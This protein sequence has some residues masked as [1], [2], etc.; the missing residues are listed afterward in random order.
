MAQPER[1]KHDHEVL[2]WPTF[3]VAIRELAGEIV[4]TGFRPDLVLAIAR[5]GL[6]VGGTMAYALGTKNCA[7]I[8]VEYYTGVDERLDL[9]VMLPPVPDP[10]G[11]DDLNVLIADDVA[12]TGRTLAMV[13]E[14]CRQHVR[15]ARTSV[16]YR[17]PWSTIDP[18]FVWRETDRWIAFPWSAEGPVDG[19]DDRG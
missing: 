8:N 1:P 4:K 9:P 17:K 15:E 14:F 13:N 6:T 7:T 18:D 11:M 2:T 19:L 12:D 10:V 16:L 5:G 3:G